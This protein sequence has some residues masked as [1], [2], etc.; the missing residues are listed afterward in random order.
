MAR[1]VKVKPRV[2]TGLAGIPMD[3]FDHAKW[4][5]HF[6]LD[7]KP[8][9]EIVKGWIK[10]NFSKA[11]S[12]AIL[13]NP[14]WNFTMHSLYATAA[15]WIRNNLEIPEKWNTV[16]D[17]LQSFYG[18]LIAPGK[19]ILAEKAEKAKADSNK[20]VL[21]PQQRLWNKVNDTIVD[22][23]VD[24]EDQWIAG[25]KTDF[26][27]YNRMRFHDIK[28]AGIE[29]VRKRIAQ[30]Q[31]D[32]SDAY[33]K[34]CDQA[35]EAYAHIDRK[36]IKRRL[37][38]CNTMLSDLDKLKASNKAVRTRIAKP[39]SAD[40]QVAKVKYQKENNDYKL[41]SINPVLI[42]GS[43]RV[44]TFN[45]KTRVLSE[46]VCESPD[47][48]E[49]SGTSLKKFSTTLSRKTTLRKPDDIIP[50]VLKKTPNQIDK[51]FKSLTTK[52]GE[53][54]GRL[55]DDTIILRALDK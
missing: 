31:A 28:G 24:L 15:F 11:D 40:K 41:A 29:I 50:I 16:K 4:Y 14:D 26:D 2:K 10:D 36:E 22:E 5:I 19:L 53:P 35:V 20:I 30:W 45:T 25:E 43:M 44:F 27:M 6:D 18:D 37:K 17:R 48:F 9:G 47:G 55:N 34:T 49:V 1:K 13:A 46:Y 51:M 8:T 42:V 23:L 32:Y 54:N 33:N 12:K 39:K 21:T 38:V 3:N 7:K 52:I